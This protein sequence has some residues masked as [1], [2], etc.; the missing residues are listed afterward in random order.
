MAF[1]VVNKFSK[2][3][4]WEELNKWSNHNVFGFKQGN[5]WQN[6]RTDHH[7]IFRFVSSHGNRYRIQVGSGRVPSPSL[8]IYCT[9]FMN[10]FVRITFCCS[11][12]AGFFILF[13]F[14][15]RP[16]TPFHVRAYV[17][18]LKSYGRAYDDVCQWH[19]TG[20]SFL[21][22]T[23]RPGL[24]WTIKNARESVCRLSSI[25]T[26]HNGIILN[27]FVFDRYNILFYL[28]NILHLSMKYM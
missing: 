24:F 27:K 1:I 28:Y 8:F 15:D 7:W 19:E 26:I 11:D 20:L 18:T 10:Y 9:N 21:L 5:K 3:T 23:L 2:S 14:R 17:G 16:P 13:F 4:V 22:V 25:G 12:I 6:F